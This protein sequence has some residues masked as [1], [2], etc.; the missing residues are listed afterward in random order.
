MARPGWLLGIAARVLLGAAVGPLALCAGLWAALFRCPILAVLCLSASALASAAASVRRC[1][2]RCS[3]GVLLVVLALG[4]AWRTPVREVNRSIARLAAIPRT[5]GA[6][7]RFTLADKLGIYGLNLA[8]AGAGMALYPEAARETL[9]LAVPVGSGE[10]RRVFKSDFPLR[11]ARISA[12]VRSFELELRNSRQRPAALSRERVAWRPGSV[13]FSP[14]DPE[15]R[16]M[17]ALNPCEVSATARRAGAQWILEVAVEVHVAYPR[18]ARTC[19]LREPELCVEEGLF[20]V[21]QEA[22]WLHPYTAIWTFSRS[23]PA[24]RGD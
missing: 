20:W 9:L 2:A 16:A 24:G 22:H 4:L 11:S 17:L 21:L 7:A 14:W 12:L 18:H 1:F 5:E 10:P 19:V 15:S 23:V 6:P 8:M 13:A 3:I